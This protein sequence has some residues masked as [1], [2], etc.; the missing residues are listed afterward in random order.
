MIQSEEDYA[1][2]LEADHIALNIKLMRPRLLQDEVWKFQRS[3]RKVEFME[4]CRKRSLRPN[5]GSIS[6]SPIFS[7]VWR[8]IALCTLVSIRFQELRKR[9]ALLTRYGS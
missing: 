8:K 7:K 2:Y 5:C 4:T 9:K 3:L 6:S 1:F